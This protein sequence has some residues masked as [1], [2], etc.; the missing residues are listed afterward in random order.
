MKTDLGLLAQDDFQ[1]NC[2]HITV[3]VIKPATGAICPAVR[4]K[5]KS[6]VQFNTGN[7][8]TDSLK[9]ADKRHARLQASFFLQWVIATHYE[10]D[11]LNR[12]KYSEFRQKP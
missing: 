2:V 7:A 6:L 9:I 1:Q 10:G 3:E 12:A 4:N 11:Q 5:E 8:D